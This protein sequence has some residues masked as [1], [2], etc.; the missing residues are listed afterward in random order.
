MSTPVQRRLPVKPL[1]A[2]AGAHSLADLARRCHVHRT[3]VYRWVRGGGITESQADRVS[4][5]LGLHPGSIWSEWF[6][7]EEV[8]S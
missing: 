4:V 7:R 2:A 5:R 1:M 3:E 8:A 6:E